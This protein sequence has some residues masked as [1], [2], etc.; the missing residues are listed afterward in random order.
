MVDQRVAALAMAGLLIMGLFVLISPRGGAAAPGIPISEQSSRCPANQFPTR[1]GS[2]GN[3]ICSYLPPIGPYNY[4]INTT[5]IFGI[6]YYYGYTSQGILKYGGPANLGGASG[7]SLSS[8]FNTLATS[9]NI[10]IHVK[11]GNFIID[12]KLKSSASNVL[13][14]GEG[15][16]TNFS[17]SAS[18]NS[19]AVLISGDNWLITQ[20]RIDARNQLTGHSY[21]TISVEGKNDTVSFSYFNR[22]DHGQINLAGTGDQALFNLVTNSNDDGITARV[23]GALI[24]G[25]IVEKTTNHN[26]ISVVGP[27]SAFQIIDNVCKSSGSNGIAIENLGGGSNTNGLVTQNTIISPAASGITV[28]PKSGAVPSAN[29]LTTSNN[30]ILNAGTGAGIQLNSGVDMNTYGNTITDSTGPAVFLGTTTSTQTNQNHI[31][32]ASIGI[33]VGGG[34]SFTQIENN[35]INRTTSY[36]IRFDSS[37]AHFQVNGNWVRNPTTYGIYASGSSYSV[38]DNHVLSSV[39]GANLIGVYLN[40]NNGTVE[41]NVLIAKASSGSGINLPSV[42]QNTVVGNFIQG[43]S[44]GISETG[45]SDYNTFSLNNVENQVTTPIAT[46]GTHDI[47][48][49]NIGFNPVATSTVTAGASIWTYVNTD[50][51]DEVMILT[52]MGG[53][54]DETCNGIVGFSITVNSNCILP[55]GSTLVVTWAGAAPVYTK[56]PLVA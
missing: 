16:G 54:T 25:N 12:S 14:S 37:T 20:I 19:N 11:T 5:T 17:L 32:D 7:T 35:Q 26:C 40:A 28:Y 30:A 33:E 44:I 22:G 6:Q 4:I 52:T 36:G 3:L 13:L 21:S 31:V 8:V 9:S 27:S 34:N 41:D 10:A 18:F 50:G 55:P 45:T 2:S 47:I 23:N 1:E 46:V 39:S 29:N 49:L 48:T 43:W 51:Y 53:I 15:S 38:N 24:K 56:V 42:S